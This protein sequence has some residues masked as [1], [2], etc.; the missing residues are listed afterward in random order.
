VI[1]TRRA[2]VQASFTRQT[3]RYRARFTRE[4]ASFAKAERDL[5]DATGWPKTLLMGVLDRESPADSRLFIRGEVSQPAD[6][7]PRG[8]VNVLSSVESRP[9]QKGSGRLELANFIASKD[10]PLTARVMVNR[11]WSKLFGR[12]LV[13]T[14][15]DFGRMGAR[16][17]HPEL[18]DYLA[19]WF[20]ERGW[21]VK[22]L[23]RE[24]MLSRAYQMSTAF[25]AKCDE[26][27]PD[28]HFVWRMS[29]RRLDAESVRDAILAVS[30]SLIEQ[31]PIGSPVALLRESRTGSDDLTKAMAGKPH[32]HRAIYLP[33]VRGQSPHALGSFDF[34]DPSMVCGQRNTTNVPSQSLFLLND[35]FVFQNSAARWKSRRCAHSCSR[36]HASRRPRSARPLPIS[37]PA[38]HHSH[39][40]ASRSPCCRLTA[41]R[42]LPAAN[43]AI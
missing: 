30:G 25:D 33:I 24:I 27:D 8:F 6:V 28:N 3:D 17:S 13:A 15:D 40:R 14:P 31:P 7:V 36:F 34:A 20:V 38:S 35:E 9:I 11:V 32:L 19:V 42:S 1:E 41:S 26:V 37:L 29:R 43:S 10:N 5:Y 23:I 22:K 2:E 21:S 4:E 12:G 18:L 16:P 39:P